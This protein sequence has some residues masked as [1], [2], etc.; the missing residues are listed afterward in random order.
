MNHQL[1]NG[2]CLLVTVYAYV[3]LTF[4]TFIVYNVYS[5]LSLQPTDDNNRRSVLLNNDVMTH[6]T[7]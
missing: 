3:F 6:P 2:A 1:N 5:F 7:M 4:A